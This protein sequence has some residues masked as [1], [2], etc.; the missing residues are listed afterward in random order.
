MN[1]NQP[2]ETLSKRHF[3]SYHQ[4]MDDY[5]K[6]A[7][8]EQEME[9]YSYF[10]QSQQYQK[11]KAEVKKILSRIIENKSFLGWNYEAEADQLKSFKS[12]Y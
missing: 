4:V 9:S 12:T 10:K 1:C 11:A 8:F 2:V 6:L 5:K 3:A 7:M